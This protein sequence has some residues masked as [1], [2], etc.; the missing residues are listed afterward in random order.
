M[1]IT[2]MAML[3]WIILNIGIQKRYKVE[4]MPILGAP[5]IRVGARQIQLKLQ[6]PIQNFCFRM[7]PK[8][9][10]T[11]KIMLSL[12]FMATLNMNIHLTLV[13]QK[14]K[15]TVINIRNF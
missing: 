7:L 11:I 10:S 1:T 5:I 9:D 13:N 6:V 12:E 15:P 3:L 4:A 8:L 14:M 2:S